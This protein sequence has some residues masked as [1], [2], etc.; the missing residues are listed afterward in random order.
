M[1]LHQGVRHLSHDEEVAHR[2]TQD[3]AER[4]ILLC[5]LRKNRCRILRLL[6][7]G[8]DPLKFLDSPFRVASVLSRGAQQLEPRYDES[9]YEYN[10]EQRAPRLQ[11]RHIGTRG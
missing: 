3:V 10:P 6:K 1:G 4:P 8:N 11:A 5:R 9:D 2:F 7:G